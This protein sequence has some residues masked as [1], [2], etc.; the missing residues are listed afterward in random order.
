MKKFLALLLSVMIFTGCASEG[1]NESAAPEA[2]DSSEK[3]KIGVIQLME[4]PS[5]NEITDAFTNELKAL[6][7]DEDK[8][9]ITIH[10]GQNDVTMMT[11]IAN[12][13]V[14][15]KVDLIVTV[16]T[17]AAQAA[18]AATSEIPIVFSAVT[19]PV[20]AGLTDSLEKPDRNLTGT[21]D[22]IPSDEILALALKLTPEVKSFGLIYNTSEV[23]SVTVINEMKKF[24]DSKSIT[25]KE[26]VVN[27]SGEVTSAAKSLVGK[28]DA[29]FLPI[30]NTVAFA[31]PNLAQISREEKIPVYVAADSMVN[32]G[33]LATVGVNY[34]NLGKQTAAMAKKVLEGQKISDTPVEVLKEYSVVVNKETADAVGVDVSEY[35][36]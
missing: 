4:H 17:P 11:Q 19:D 13:L 12:K 9:E 21:S 24:M 15:D 2:S 5:L 1:K 23:N 29:F 33:G 7:Y 32:D 26:A 35:V 25:Y 8:A 27:T 36:K 34:T 30:D 31:M 3:I 6:G 14:G 16:A 18:A 20:A 28:V 22:R 10:N